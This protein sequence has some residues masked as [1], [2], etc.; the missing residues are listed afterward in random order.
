MLWRLAGEQWQGRGLAVVLVGSCALLQGGGQLSWCVCPCQG[1]SLMRPCHFHMRWGLQSSGF[2][3]Q[4]GVDCLTPLRA[5]KLM[6]QPTGV[7]GSV[8]C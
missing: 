4:T 2:C 8:Q 5:Y 3:V 1:S 6:F 7:S